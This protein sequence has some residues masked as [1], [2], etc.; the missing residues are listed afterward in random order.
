MHMSNQPRY[1]KAHSELVAAEFQRLGWTLVKEFREAPRQEPYEYLL[2]WR[3]EG[4]PVAINWEEFHRK[5]G[6]AHSGTS[7]GRGGK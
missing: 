1:A 7:P 5:H 3:Q 2:D 4:P 6:N